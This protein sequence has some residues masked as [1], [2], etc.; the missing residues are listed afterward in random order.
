ML[1]KNAKNPKC[2]NTFHISSTTRMQQFVQLQVS[3]STSPPNSKDLTNSMALSN[4]LSAAL[5][6]NMASA[7]SNNSGSTPM[8]RAAAQGFA[9]F[10][11]TGR[12]SL[13]VERFEDKVFEKILKIR[14]GSNAILPTFWN[15]FEDHRTT[16]CTIFTISARTAPGSKPRSFR[17]DPAS[18]RLLPGVLRSHR[19]GV[20]AS[21]RPAAL[22]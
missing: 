3:S 11:L 17:D 22:G 6:H 13:A 21:M 2:K 7:S 5:V 1:P 10:S 18:T 8:A 9:E 12:H 4:S 19:P 15:G 20:L 16:H 14:F